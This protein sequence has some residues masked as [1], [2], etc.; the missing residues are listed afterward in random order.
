MLDPARQRSL[1]QCLR[2]LGVPEIPTLDWQQ[3]DQALTHASASAVV[4]YEHLEFLGDA[5]LRLA[6]AEFLLESYPQATV[7]ELAAIRSR[8]VS[9]QTLADIAD[10]LGLETHL[11][12]SAGASRD[13]AGRRSRLADAFEAVLGALYLHDHDLR[14]I[15]PWLDPHMHRLAEQIRQDP[16][17]QNYKAALQEMTQAACGA[18]PEYRTEEVSQIHGDLQRFASTVW[19]QQR[20]WGTG[21]G[22]S[23]KQ[24]EQA[25][26]RM[27]YAP[28]KQA[29]EHS[30][31]LAS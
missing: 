4:N 1:Q 27:A 19:F 22:S 6:A 5:A 17:L 21:R 11:R 15:R 28:L 12:V 20:S 18:L 9:D 16:T 14:L 29:L 26:A 24:A 8:L 10:L 23:M 13:L 2:K 3:L 31:N 25:A 7:G 30:K